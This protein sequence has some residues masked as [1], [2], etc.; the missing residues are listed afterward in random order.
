[1]KAKRKCFTRS[2]GLNVLFYV[3][4]FLLLQMNLNIPFLDNFAGSLFAAG[5]VEGMNSM[6]LYFLRYFLTTQV[7]FW[8]I[9]L[10]VKKR[11]ENN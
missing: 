2:L 10:I 4:I 8:G 3:A 9:C 1:M 5:Y 6:I 7:V 11:N